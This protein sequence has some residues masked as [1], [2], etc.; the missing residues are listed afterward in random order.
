[1]GAAPTMRQ[2]AWISAIRHTPP[3]IRRPLNKLRNRV[4]PNWTAPLDIT[5]RGINFRCHFADN[6]PEHKLLFQGR[7]MDR[8]HLAQL[9][10]YQTPGATFVDIG[11]NFGF[12]SLNACRAIGE[13]GSIL[14]FEPNPVMA[15]R[16]RDNIKHN[17]F[18]NIIVE[19]CAVGH[20]NGVATGRDTRNVSVVDHGS[21]SYRSSAAFG[22][23]DNGP[24]SGAGSVRMVTLLDALGRHKIRQIDALKIDIEGHEAAALIPFFEAAPRHLFPRMILMEESHAA[25]WSEDVIGRLTSIGYRITARGR[26]DIVLCR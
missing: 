14:A 26:M 3:W 19:E 21:V 15:A 17:N 9:Q 4:E 18:K 2:A 5:L 24:A 20:T 7:R 13:R 1:M 6:T 16:F 11:A 10:P 8:W 22:E 12:F 25:T 23:P